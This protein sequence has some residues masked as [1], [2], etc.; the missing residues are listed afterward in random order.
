MVRTGDKF[1]QIETKLPIDAYDIGIVP[2]LSNTDLLLIGG[3]TDNKCLNSICKFSAI[4]CSADDG[5][6]P[7]LEYSIDEVSSEIEMKPDF[8]S[9][10]SMMVVDPENADVVTI[11]GA[12]YKH[13]FV[14]LNIG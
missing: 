5:S 7:S 13:S 6:Q 12:Q 14:G 2:Q 1:E 9:Y 8:F 10:T 4:P 11:F 3:Y